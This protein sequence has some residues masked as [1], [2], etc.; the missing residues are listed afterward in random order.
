MMTL[1]NVDFTS[2]FNHCFLIFLSIFMSEGSYKVGHNQKWI[3][4]Q[5]W[6]FVEV[7]RAE[8]IVDN[9]SPCSNNKL[10]RIVQCIPVASRRLDQNHI[11]SW[12][13][14]IQEQCKTLESIRAIYSIVN[15]YIC[16]YPQT[17]WETIWIWKQFR[18]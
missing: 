5:L 11:S 12:S 8:I 18:D 1:R 13:S 10:S 17:K 6:I 4:V 3:V 14:I 7:I 15:L 2:S 16:P 9:Y